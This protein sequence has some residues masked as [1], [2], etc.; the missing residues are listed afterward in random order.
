MACV[1]EGLRCPSASSSSLVWLVPPTDEGVREVA[2]EAGDED[3][4]RN[5]DGHSFSRV[6]HRGFVRMERVGTAS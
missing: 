2:G 5:A 6:K 1:G 4:Q 3:R